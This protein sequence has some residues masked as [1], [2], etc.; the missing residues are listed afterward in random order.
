M[1]Y[2][3]DAPQTVSRWSANYPSMKGNAVPPKT[4]QSAEIQE[5]ATVEETPNFLQGYDDVEWETI[6]EEAAI[7]VV[8]DEVGD[9][10]I[11]AFIGI[12]HISPEKDGQE[13]FDRYLFRAKDGK[14]Y[15]IP[16]S[17]KLIEAMDKVQP[18]QVTR[19]EYVKDIPTGRK[20]NPMKDFTVKVARTKP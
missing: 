20:Q 8:F 19:I 14:L 17:Y 2:N 16:Q 9:V 10:F 7:G 4:R 11:G 13:P 6:A 1:K 5:D 12:E 18:G 3:W 15:A